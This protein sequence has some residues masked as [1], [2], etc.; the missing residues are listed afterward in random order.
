LNLLLVLGLAVCL[1]TPNVSAQSA[2]T[3][4]KVAPGYLIVLGRATDR[5]KIM[6]YSATLPPIYAATGGRYIGLGRSGAGVTCVYGLCEGR[7]AVIAH[8]A[9]HT[10][11]E[12]FWWGEAY[13]KAVRLRDGAGAFTVVGL[14]GSPNITP[15]PAPGALLI[16]TVNANANVTSAPAAQTWLDAA[17]AAN[18]RLLAPFTNAALSPLEGDALYNR[19]AMLSFESKEKRDAFAASAATQTFINTAPPLHLVAL[20]AVDTPAPQ[21]VPAVQAQ[22]VTSK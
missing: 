12:A 8:W 1:L 9:D 4:E 17:I 19:I 22:P 6:A 16:A 15:Y 5:A 11:V 18:A 7:S 20:I 10:S 13:R 21:A 14:K 2:P 3:L